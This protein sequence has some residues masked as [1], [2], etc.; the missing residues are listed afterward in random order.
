VRVAHQIIYNVDMVQWLVDVEADP[1]GPVVHRTGPVHPN[2]ES[3]I[4]LPIAKID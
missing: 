3:C 4:F 2:I 1:D